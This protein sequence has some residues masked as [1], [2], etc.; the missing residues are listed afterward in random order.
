MANLM[1]YLN[2][3][4]DLS[5]QDSTMNDVDSLL[6]SNLSYV[7]F[8]T[9][10]PSPWERE[11]VPLWRA[12][13]AYWEQNRE[14]ELLQRFSL[15]KMAPF[16]MRRMAETKRFREIPLMYYQNSINHQVGSQFSAMCMQLPNHAY[17][18]AFRGTDDTIIGWR[19]NFRMSYEV[20]PAQQK[21]VDYLN[22]VGERC[23]GALWLGGHSKG[24]NLA[25]YAAVHARP[26]IQ[27]RI[28]RIYNFDGPGFSKQMLKSERY[29]RMA[30]RIC[31]YVPTESVIGMLL[32]QDENYQVVSSMGQGLQQHDPV[33]WRILGDQFV[34]MPRQQRTGRQIN[35]VV[36]DW[37]YGLSLEE[38]R[39]V[40]E[41]VFQAMEDSHVETL[42]DL[43]RNQWK[44]KLWM[45]RE[46][47]RENQEC[48]GML[49]R[50]G[51]QMLYELH[52]TITGR[53][54]S[55]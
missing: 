22:Y 1:D 12:S 13:E 49:K 44:K 9:I 48:Y 27:R 42:D 11:Q 24:G 7:A 34:Y 21:A 46:K 16:S 26:E 32:E 15:I 25:V 8:D 53:I 51:K 17:Y 37:I 2:W 10:L 41:A 19:E 6:F 50:A 30:D 55:G 18:L 38:R 35:Q 3:R 31:K 36:H 43:G 39:Q 23:Q 28:Q 47:L 29:R 52:K 20:V 40:V 33:N 54:R 14:Q 45:V 5:F 4:G